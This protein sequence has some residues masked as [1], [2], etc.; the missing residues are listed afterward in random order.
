MEIKTARVREIKPG[1]VAFETEREFNPPDYVHHMRRVNGEMHDPL[2]AACLGTASAWAYSDADTFARMM[3]LHGGI[4]HNETAS[5]N[6]KNNGLLIDIKAFVTQSK[7]KDLAVLAFSGTDPVNLIQLLM[8]VTAKRHKGSELR[9]VHG[10]FFRAAIALWPTIRR[11]LHFALGGASLCSGAE[12]EREKSLDEC[13]PGRGAAP[14]GAS[15]DGEPSLRG[16]LDPPPSANDQAPMSALYITGHSLGGALA[17][18]TAAL[19]YRDAESAPI[20]S[21]LRAI[22]TYGQPMVGNE[23]FANEFQNSIGRRLFRHV[24]GRDLVPSLPSRSAGDFKHFGTELKSDEEGWLPRR[25]PVPQS[26]SFVLS[27]LA[28]VAAFAIEQLPGVPML[29]RLRMPVSLYDHL[30]FNYLLTSQKIPADSGFR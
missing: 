7:N 19:I 25:E 24:H 18:L 1:G 11:L 13:A 15:P 10:G 27:L 28:G 9:G 22:Y 30:P 23:D 17:V 26:W 5:V 21:R 3:H 29:Q 6:L 20:R 2:V 14:G 4:P 8:D 16:D 12:V